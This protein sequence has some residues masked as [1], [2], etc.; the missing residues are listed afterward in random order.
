MADTS[1][2]VFLYQTLS[3]LGPLLTIVDG[4]EQIYGPGRLEGSPV[5]KPFVNV[6]SE[7]EIPAPIPGRSVSSWAV[8]VHDDPGDY[9]RIQE[10]LKAIRAALAPDVGGV[11]Q[12]LGGIC[13]WAGDS[14]GYSDEVLK[15]IYRYSTYQFFGK[16]GEE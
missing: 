8:Y 11:G 13:R 6:A 14:P 15:T 12:H 4:V 2:D 7:S 10:A 9:G 16:D 1:W 3:N 5:K